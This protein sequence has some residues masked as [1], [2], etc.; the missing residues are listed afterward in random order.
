MKKLPVSIA[1]LLGAV[2]SI[3]A[4]AGG[5]DNETHMKARYYYLEGS[6]CQAMD[7]NVAAYEYFKKAYMTDTSY[8]EA[9]NAY[10]MNRLMVKTDTLQSNVEL[11]R[12]MELIRKF[13]DKYP[14]DKNEA[15]SY[16]YVASRLDTISETVRV[17]ER[18]DSLYPTDNM[19]LLQL[20]EA[21]LRADMHDKAIATLDRY[22][23]AE[24]K[25]PQVS[26]KKMSIR[27]ADG[28]TVGAIDEATT[29]VASNPSDPSLLLI[30]GNL[31][32]AIEKNDSAISY[33]KMAENLSP[34]NGAAKI[35]LAKF[36]KNIG[37]SLSSDSKMYE[38]LLSEDFVLE[39]K[40]SFLQEYLQSLLNDKSDM[41]RGDHLFSVLKEQYPHEPEVLDLA[42]RYSG[43]KG[44]YRDAEE[45]IEYAI[46]LDPSNISYWG[47]LMR[48]QLA[49]E[50]GK[51]AMQT[52]ERAKQHVE[53]TNVLTLM[54]ASAATAEKDYETAERAYAEL[55]REPNPDLPLTDSITDTKFR[56]S[57]S[58]DGLTQ[59]CSLYT[60]LGDMYYAA[61]ELDKTFRAYDNALFFY[62]SNPMT[63]NNYAYFLA[64]NGGDLD[65]AME[66]SR[67]AIDQEPE[68]DIY[69]D[70]F[71][72]ILFKRKDYAGALDYQKKAVGLSEENGEPASE[73]YHHF[74][75][76]L[77]MN[78]MPAEALENWR[79]ALELEPDNALLKKKVDHK[80]FFFE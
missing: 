76:I 37:D 70:T 2:I 53:V 61:G 38:A 21:Y 13:V 40:L 55:I 75:D 80:T 46:D 71:A 54:Y 26:F 64:E 66:M 68:N 18:L 43:A 48:Y 1:L 52:Y 29:L 57:L 6:R 79:K 31:Y 72:W 74:G 4:A 19:N 65:R 50:R 58:F 16:A 10:G 49:D 59:L 7:D 15:Y 3:T 5:K 56:N 39:E 9:A 34:D 24:G 33:Y 51:D 28:D 73:Y 42:A 78:H 14:A 20:A 63:L 41:A 45:Q 35:T 47:Q 23:T 67:K 8:V 44:D 11:L 27:L 32:E 12:S 25:S 60:M 30:K 22:E 62:S 69:L 17:Y 77:F 36:Y